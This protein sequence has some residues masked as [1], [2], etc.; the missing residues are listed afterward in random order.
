[1]HLAERSPDRIGGK[2]RLKF[3]HKR[4]GNSQ[5]SQAG[6][7]FLPRILASYYFIFSRKKKFTFWCG[8]SILRAGIR[9]KG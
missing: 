2:A 4:K 7:H 9:E 1:M 8:I 3:E 6:I 5:N